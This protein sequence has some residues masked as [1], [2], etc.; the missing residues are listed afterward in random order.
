MKGDIIRRAEKWYGGQIQD[1]YFRLRPLAGLF[2]HIIT[3]EYTGPYWVTSRKHF[4]FW[5]I[6][7]TL[8]A[9]MPSD[10]S[11]HPKAA[12]YILPLLKYLQI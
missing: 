5:R 12:K 7:F 8:S 4:L 2:G 1:G 6:I 10:L 11:D 9:M 3:S